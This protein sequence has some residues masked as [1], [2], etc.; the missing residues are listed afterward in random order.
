[1]EDIEWSYDKQKGSSPLLYNIESQIEQVSSQIKHPKFE[2]YVK[3]LFTYW[4][5]IFHFPDD[6]GWDGR[7]L[8]W[9]LIKDETGEPY[10]V[11]H[12]QWK[13]K[14]IKNANGKYEK[15]DY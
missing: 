14:I 12:R 5:V 3:T 2:E 9:V 7:N 4:D 6:D 13:G 15:K 10:E 11:G 1:M 8:M